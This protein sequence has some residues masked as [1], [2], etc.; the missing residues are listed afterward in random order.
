MKRIIFGLLRQGSFQSQT[1]NQSSIN[2]LLSMVCMLKGPTPPIQ[3]PLLSFF[4]PLYLALFCVVNTC[5]VNLD[6]QWQLHLYNKRWLLPFY[7]WFL[8]ELHET[9]VSTFITEFLFATLSI[10]LLFQTARFSHKPLRI[11]SSQTGKN[12]VMFFLL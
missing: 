2:V 4:D 11:G 6:C 7:T 5:Y 9:D 10:F 1:V 12:M 3:Y 8:E